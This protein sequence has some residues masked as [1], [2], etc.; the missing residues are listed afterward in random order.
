MLLTVPRSDCRSNE[1]GSEQKRFRVGGV[2]AGAKRV[3]R[4]NTCG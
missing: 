2:L 4:E 3:R 1:G